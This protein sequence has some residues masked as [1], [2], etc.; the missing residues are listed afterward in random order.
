MAFVQSY[1]FLYNVVMIAGWGYI[2]AQVALNYSNGNPATKVYGA[3]I[4]PLTYFQTAAFIEILHA[5]IGLVPSPVVTTFIQVMSRVAV[6]WG[7]LHIGS[8][9]TNESFA[10]TTLCVAWCLAELIRYS[11]YAFEVVS[12]GSCP[13]VLRVARYS[14]F[15]V[16]YPL[17]IS[18]EIACWYNS[19]D[20]VAR[21]KLFTVAMPNAW[22]FGFDYY[23]FII[24]LLVVCYPPGSYIMYTYML[25]QRKKALSKEKKN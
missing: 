11:F 18:S 21:K 9:N 25:S 8:K 5:A 15:L 20:Y 2:L 23:L 7:T 12:K 6:V 13:T 4:Q 3:I 10:V 17:G 19:L 14:G 1:L 22:N 24:F 16:L